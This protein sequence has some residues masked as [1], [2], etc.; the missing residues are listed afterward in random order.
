MTLRMRPIRCPAILLAAIVL[1]AAGLPGQAVARLAGDVRPAVSAHFDSRADR[2]RIAQRVGNSCMMM[3]LPQA[4]SIASQDER[5][6]VL[7]AS[8]GRELEVVLRPARAARDLPQAD[9]AS[10]DAALLQQDH[11]GLFGRP[12]QAA[13]LVS[14]PAGAKRWTATWIDASLPGASREVTLDTLIVPFSDEWVL[15]LSLAQAGTP[16]A[17]EQLMTELLTGLRRESADACSSG[18]P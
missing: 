11:E 15:E 9:P 16:A 12:A 6:I 2:T 18:A 1:L 13:T 5:R 7:S 4:W 3:I 10:R 14:L 17:Y 8:D